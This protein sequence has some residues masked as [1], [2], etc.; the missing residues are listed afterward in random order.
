MTTPASARPRRARRAR[1]PAWFCLFC[2]S[3]LTRGRGNRWRCRRCGAAWTLR[4]N[5][6]ECVVSLRVDNCGAGAECC[7]AARC[8]AR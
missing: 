1:P 8:S 2:A 3:A 6:R 4:R 5:A 7:R